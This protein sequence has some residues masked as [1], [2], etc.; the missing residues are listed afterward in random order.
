MIK[1]TLQA[2]S[3][4]RQWNKSYPQS[5]M[6]EE[7]RHLNHLH[8]IPDDGSLNLGESYDYLHFAGDPSNLFSLHVSMSCRE[9]SWTFSLQLKQHHGKKLRLYK[10]WISN[11][12]SDKRYIY[13]ISKGFVAPAAFINSTETGN[14]GLE[15]GWHTQWRV[16]GRVK[17][18]LQEDCSFCTWTACSNHDNTETDSA[19]FWCVG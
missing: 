17:W 5:G 7:S 8:S 14:Q 11:Y 15:S 2:F 13:F 16:T 18:P 6:V 19:A 3:S 10:T 9:L 4:W 1:G 12:S